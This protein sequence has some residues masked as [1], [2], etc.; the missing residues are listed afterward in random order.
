MRW[1][2]R[3]RRKPKILL[4]AFLDC[5]AS[6]DRQIGHP[7]KCCA[8]YELSS[9]WPSF[10]PAKLPK[11]RRL[12]MVRG[13]GRGN[14]FSI[15]LN[16]CQLRQ[17]FFPLRFSH[18]NSSFFT[19]SPNRAIPASCRLLRSSYNGL[20]IWLWLFPKVPWSS[21]SRPS[22]RCPLAPPTTALSSAIITSSS[23]A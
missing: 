13:F 10:P 15:S 3:I 16:F 5:H 14:R 19:S 6:S 11:R 21:N 20:S 1:T 4:S 18:F 9:G 7:M 22:S 2:R 8:V 12:T 17:F 23:R